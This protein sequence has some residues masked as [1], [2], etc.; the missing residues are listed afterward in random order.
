MIAQAE[1][2]A[3]AAGLGGYG[4]SG[5]LVTPAFGPAVRL[6]GVVTD[7]D[8]APGDPLPLTPCIH[9]R[10]CV[11]ACP[12]GALS[13]GGR[14][15]KKKCGDRIFAGGFRAWRGFLMDLVEASPEDRRELLKSRLSLELWQNFMT[16]NY[17]Y[18]FA[19]Q[20]ECPVGRGSRA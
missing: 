6:G 10:A 2:A 19:C 5:L 4:E 20:A 13:G 3:V 14:I 18:C 15:D 12:T 1:V 17:Y 8:V 11:E 7:A 16:G 9:C